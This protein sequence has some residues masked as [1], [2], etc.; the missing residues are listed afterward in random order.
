MAKGKGAQ[1]R[2][3]SFWVRHRKV[4]EKGAQLEV[5]ILGICYLGA[6]NSA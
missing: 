5:G 1:Q 3:V 2:E 4:E 6:P